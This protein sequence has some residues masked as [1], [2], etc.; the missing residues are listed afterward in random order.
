M[1]RANLHYFPIMGYSG[2]ARLVE[3]IGNTLLDRKD[4]DEPD[5]LLETIQ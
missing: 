2:A 3:R 4:R 5:W 1:D